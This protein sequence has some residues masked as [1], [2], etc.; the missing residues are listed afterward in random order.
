MWELRHHRSSVLAAI[1]CSGGL[2]AT[3]TAAGPRTRQVPDVGGISIMAGYARAHH[4]GLLVSTAGRSLDVGYGFCAPVVARQVPSAGSRTRTG[5]VKLFISGPVPCSP[6][7]PTAPD[8]VP[9]AVLPSFVGWRLDAVDRWARAH[10]QLW[11]ALH[12]EPLSGGH[13]ASL[14]GGYR[15]AA[16]DQPPGT[17]MTPGVMQDGTWVATP[18]TLHAAPRQGLP[19]RP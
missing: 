12:L 3:P 13:A 15:V 18:M 6:G 10:G 14:L 11:R 9:S 16:Q 19:P 17:R 4:A 7:T 1:L 5:R 2:L 8:P